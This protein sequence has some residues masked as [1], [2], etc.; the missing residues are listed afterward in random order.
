MEYWI[1]NRL[2]VASYQDPL[3]SF[4]LLH[5]I[6]TIQHNGYPF[7]LVWCSCMDPRLPV[8][9]WTCT[10]WAST[11]H[12]ILMDDTKQMLYATRDHPS[13]IDRKPHDVRSIIPDLKHHQSKPCRLNEWH[14]NRN[15]IQERDHAT[16]RSW[17]G[18]ITPALTS[19]TRHP[20]VEQV[21]ENYIKMTC[22]LA[23]KIYSWFNLRHIGFMH[24]YVP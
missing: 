18:S 24:L 14:V 23:N 4:S 3:V 12:H 1:L 20:P 2:C 16:H 5:Q 8:Y 10:N 21:K 6:M 11:S 19:R 9:M 22:W 7:S 15:R 17:T 13:W